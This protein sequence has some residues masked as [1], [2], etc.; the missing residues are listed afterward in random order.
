MKRTITYDSV[1]ILPDEIERLL[2]D[3]EEYITAD[4]G[5]ADKILCH[6][7]WLKHGCIDWFAKYLSQ[8]GA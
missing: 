1:N 4:N 5:E 2:R 8:E 7:S 6:L 3:M